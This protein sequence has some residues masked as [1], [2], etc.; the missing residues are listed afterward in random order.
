MLDNWN[1]ANIVTV[2]IT[3]KTIIKLYVDSIR[4]RLPCTSQDV[5]ALLGINRITFS[6]FYTT[7]LLF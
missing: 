2:N 1:V 7:E 3:N 5:K 4:N 6:V